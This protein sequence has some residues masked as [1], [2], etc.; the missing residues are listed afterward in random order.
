MLC[1][2]LRQRYDFFLFDPNKNKENFLFFIP[3]DYLGILPYYIYVVFAAKRFYMICFDI[4][5]GK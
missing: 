5:L 2:F 1:L 3:K 4:Y